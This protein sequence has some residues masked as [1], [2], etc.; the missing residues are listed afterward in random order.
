MSY[1]IVVV[2]VKGEDLCESTLYTVKDDIYKLPLG[3][4]YTFMDLFG[5]CTKALTPENPEDQKLN[6]YLLDTL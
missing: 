2:S 4:Q 3:K 5:S 1:Y 6:L